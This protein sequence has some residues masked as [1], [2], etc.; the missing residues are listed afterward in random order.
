MKMRAV[1][2][3]PGQKDSAH[4]SNISIPE[5]GPGEVRVRVIEVGVDGT[6][7]DINAGLYGDVPPGEDTL[8]IG[9]EAVGIVDAIGP[10]VTGIFEGEL[11]VPTV[12]RGC[13]ES[14]PSCKQLTPDMCITGNYEERGIS[15]QQGFMADYFVERPD[16]LLKLPEHLRETGVLVEPTSICEKALSQIFLI[17][18]RLPWSPQMA[19]VL[20]AGNIGLLST[21]LLRNMG[22]TTYTADIEPEDSMKA[23]LVRRVGAT[24]INVKQ[25]LLLD[26]P[27]EIGEPDIVIESTGYSRNSFDAM[28][29]VRN[30]GIVSMIS[31]TAGHKHEQ[32]CTDCI[33]EKMVMGNRV[34]F[35]SV[36][37]NRDHFQSAIE[38]MAVIN[39]RWPGIYDEMVTRRVP[40]TEFKTALNK[41]P[42]DIKPVVMIAA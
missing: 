16:N 9:H 8:V 2:V 37:S 26:F 32:I 30:N 5:P 40:I 7:I 12:R 10:N 3:I 6:D 13:R 11:V 18:E 21:F 36:S 28:Q 4:L 38:H 34:A 20:G 39:H 35:G 1:T 23:G 29:I 14:C 33:E 42:E 22:I 25:M 41:T 19:L 31:V 27:N 24:Y 15:K 17:Q